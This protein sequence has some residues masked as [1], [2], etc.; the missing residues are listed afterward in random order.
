MATEESLSYEMVI[1]AVIPLPYLQDSMGLF[2]RSTH[3]TPPLPLNDGIAEGIAVQLLV[4]SLTYN[5]SCGH[6]PWIR[7]LAKSLTL[8]PLLRS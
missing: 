1:T 8:S 3:I 5:G 4:M 6:E 7:A 2:G